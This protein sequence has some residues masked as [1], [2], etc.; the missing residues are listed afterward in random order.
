MCMCKRDR[1]REWTRDIKRIL[2][3]SLNL[4]HRAGQFV[5]YLCKNHNYH[6]QWI[7]LWILPNGCTDI[8]ACSSLLFSVYSNAK[9][10]WKRQQESQ[11]RK[12]VQHY[13]LSIE[14]ITYP[15]LTLAFWLLD[16]IILQPGKCLSV[17]VGACVCRCV[18]LCVG[19]M[20]LCVYVSV[21]MCGWG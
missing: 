19:G 17:C 3:P 12:N 18:C 1:K 5:A 10:G 6:W 14:E 11:I 13:I 2:F 20:H 21:C 4:H 8:D 7:L 15:S 9:A 16:F